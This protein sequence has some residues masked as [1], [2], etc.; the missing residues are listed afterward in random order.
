M[1]PA[2]Q[3]RPENKE[4]TDLINALFDPIDLG[5]LDG[6]SSFLDGLKESLIINLGIGRGEYICRLTVQGDIV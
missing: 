6:L 2:N 3:Q 5:A 4:I 1:I